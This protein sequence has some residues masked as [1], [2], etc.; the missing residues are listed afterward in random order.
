[1]APHRVDARHVRELLIAQHRYE[2]VHAV[3]HG[4]VT[5]LAA[6]V[7]ALWIAMKGAVRAGSTLGMAILAGWVCLAGIALPAGAF[8]L[9][10]RRRRDQAAAVLPR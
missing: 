6:A 2:H 10:W 8:E 7:G 5:L 3:R 4:A 9:L 1:M